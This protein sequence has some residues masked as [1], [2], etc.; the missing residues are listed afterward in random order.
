M[1]RGRY[2]AEVQGRRLILDS[3]HGL[4]IGTHYNFFYLPAS[5]LVLSAETR[6]LMTPVQAMESCLLYTSPSP[7]D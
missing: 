2:G 6:G 3:G 4:S 7:R 5:G 1:G